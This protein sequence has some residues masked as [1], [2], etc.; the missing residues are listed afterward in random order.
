MA[1]QNVKELVVFAAKTAELIEGLAEGVSFDDV[2]KL[3]AVG[4][5]AGPAFKDARLALTE[6]AAMTD[7]EA[8]DLEAY[9]SAQLDLADDKVEAAIELALKVAI[10]LHELVALLVKPVP[11][12]A[13]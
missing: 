3:I 1:T 7:A 6:Y 13:A 5:A 10:Q 12:P 8:A 4:R 2:A 11:V 9:V